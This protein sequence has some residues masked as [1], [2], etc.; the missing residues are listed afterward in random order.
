MAGL[1][2]FALRMAVSLLSFSSLVR[3]QEQGLAE[4]HRKWL[5]CD[6]VW[7]FSEDTVGSSFSLKISFHGSPVAGKRI[8]LEK[9]RQVA[10]TT[11]TN[12]H[13]I[14][15]FDSV[16]PGEYDPGS[17]DGLLFP[18]GSLVIEV[19]A[20]HPPG[21]KIAFDW[22]GYSYAYRFWRGRFTIAE[23]E[24][25]PGT[26]LRN[27]VLELRNVYTATLIESG[28]TDAN[29]DHEFATTDAGLYALRLVLPSK[30]RESGFENRDLPVILDP[31]AKEVSI[32]E[33]KVVPSDCAG[34]QLFR[35]SAADE[36]WEAQ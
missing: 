28:S 30:K 19:Q 31:A 9:G 12:Q 8:S 34:I 14:A 13:G 26:P 21:E 36:H 23:Q 16:P 33:M 35:R 22:P 27:T 29:G 2:V 1:K 4:P 3:A 18:S 15:Q 7:G 10:A 20:G 5:D 24:N 32:S 6:V 25:K 17:P 11:T